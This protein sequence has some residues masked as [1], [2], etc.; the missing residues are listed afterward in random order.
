MAKTLLMNSATDLSFD[1]FRQGAGRVH[2]G[3]AAALALGQ[4]GISVEP[5]LWTAGDYRGEQY[6]SYANILFPGDTFQ[7]GF[8]IMNEGPSPANVLVSDVR[9]EEFGHT[10]FAMDTVSSAS[11]VRSF[12]QP[13]YLTL[14]EGPGVNHIP[15]GTSLVVFEAIYPFETFDFDYQPGDPSTVTPPRENSYRLL[16]GDWADMNHNGRLYDDSL[17]AVPGMVEANEI[18]AGE[19]MRF[20]YGYNTATSLKAF[21]ADPLSR[22]H[23]GIWVGLQHR[24]GPI[25]TPAV[26]VRIRA[27]YFREVDCPWLTTNTPSVVIPAGGTSVVTATVQVPG[28][29]PLGCYSAKLLLEG[30]PPKAEN[31]QVDKGVEADIVVVPVSLNVAANLGTSAVVISGV[32]EFSEPY[33]NFAVHGDF[34][35]NDRTESGDG[36]FFFFDSVNPAT[37]SFVV[38]RTTWQDP[39]PTDIDTLILGPISD[40]YTTPGTDYYL[41][42]F[43][44]NRLAH[45]GGVRSPGRPNW[46]FQTATGGSTDYSVAN[47]TDG[48]HG[49]FVHN[50]LFGG[51]R[52]AVPFQ[53]DMG[54]LNLQPDPLQ[55][56]TM[57]PAVSENLTLAST[58]LFN[59]FQVDAF[60]PSPVW[61]YETMPISQNYYYYVNFQAT[62][63]G[64]IDV[65]LN[66]P[67]RDLDLY[68]YR[69]G[70][71][72]SVPDGNFNSPE[73]IYRSES[74]ASDEFIQAPFPQ[75]GLYQAR[76]YAYAV[77]EATSYFNLEIRRVQGKNATLTPSSLGTVNPGIPESTQ[78]GMNLP[79]LGE[80][81]VFLTSGPSDAPR[82]LNLLMPVYYFKE[83]DADH[84][85][86]VDELDLFEVS[87][88]WLSM[89][90]VPAG[91]DFN[92]N[93]ELEAQDLLNFLGLY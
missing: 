1:V 55:I 4:D 54:V 31:G 26:H 50:I 46:T 84:N 74:I 52:F 80:Y 88:K 56:L 24:Y 43:G 72:G 41:P 30:L 27:R 33:Q 51:S 35:W 90:G 6:S 63:A 69:D 25:P 87:R 8:Q 2:A 34:S 70:A 83:G 61:R 47:L 48:L 71:D 20:N 21:V 53:V 81:A 7:Q 18:D 10:D 3:R 40:T 11:E 42:G 39:P 23:D 91:V 77:D 44:P 62:D 60:G 12:S 36:R 68:L 58:L 14:F 22:M 32:T 38:T 89:Q 37:G 79:S 64:L 28:N 92:H 29:M 45:I 17:G 57:I 85:N 5:P 73:V 13:D 65:R 16:V 82:A 67:A 49:L 15:L 86:V 66:S 9:L 93:G 78:I 59:D 76:V 19:Y 75:D